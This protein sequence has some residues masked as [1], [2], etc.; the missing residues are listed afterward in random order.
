MGNFTSFGVPLKIGLKYMPFP[1]MNVGIDFQANL[2][3]EKSF[4]NTFLSLEF[5]IIRNPMKAKYK[6]Q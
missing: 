3:L 4:F 2:N 5:G 1:F 6:E